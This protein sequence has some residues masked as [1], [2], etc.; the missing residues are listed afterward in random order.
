MR[1][2]FNCGIGFVLYA[3]E[4]QVESI[5]SDLTAAGETAFVCGTLQAA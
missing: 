1:R 5:I 3:D 2:T 4:S